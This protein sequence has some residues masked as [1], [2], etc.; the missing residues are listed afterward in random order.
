MDPPYLGLLKGEYG[1]S[2]YGWFKNYQQKFINTSRFRPI[3]H[4]M[5]FVL[6]LGYC[7]EYPHLKRARGP[8]ARARAAR[9]R[10]VG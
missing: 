10:G 9:R 3:Q 2:K 6:V 8:H 7:L 5:A 4:V 1:V